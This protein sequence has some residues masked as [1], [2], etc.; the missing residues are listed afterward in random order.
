M[1]S[2]NENTTI[3]P[4]SSEHHMLCFQTTLYSGKEQT[5][6]RG[7]EWSQQ[8][9]QWEP[10]WVKLPS[11]S[12]LNHFLTFGNGQ[13]YDIGLLGSWISEPLQRKHM[14]QW[15]ATNTEFIYQEK[16]VNIIYV[17][18]PW[19]LLTFQLFQRKQK[20]LFFVRLKKVSK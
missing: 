14:T 9:I 4:W 19:I 15:L 8:T 11:T 2:M 6:L 17:L 3:L 12:P 5:N 20:N 7:L 1:R 10:R 16:D 13:L 18:L